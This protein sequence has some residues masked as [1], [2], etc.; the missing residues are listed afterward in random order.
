MDNIH[1][2]KQ[3]LLDAVKRYNCTENNIYYFVN[4]TNQIVCWSTSPEGAEQELMVY[5]NY[6]DIDEIEYMHK[7]TPDGKT[8]KSKSWNSDLGEVG[9]GED[10]FKIQ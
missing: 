3:E 10:G 1:M 5:A 9:F 2:T 6:F 8:I 7:R 4:S